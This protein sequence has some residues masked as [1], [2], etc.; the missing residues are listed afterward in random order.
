MA[1]YITCHDPY[2]IG[3]NTLLYVVLFV[4]VGCILYYFEQPLFRIYDGMCG[5]WGDFLEI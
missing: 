3:L 1:F 2:F 4:L 5:C